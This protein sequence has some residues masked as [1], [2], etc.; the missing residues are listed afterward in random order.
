V[1]ED[2]KPM[3]VFLSVCYCVSGQH[4]G[5]EVSKLLHLSL[6]GLCLKLE[7]FWCTQ[8]QAA[9]PLCGFTPFFVEAYHLKNAKDL[10]F[11]SSEISSQFL[12][13]RLQRLSAEFPGW[14]FECG[15]FFACVEVHGVLNIC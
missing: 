4:C 12:R 2:V 14:Y 3:V 13:Q 1:D 5:V 8:I 6:S 7:K 10:L 15:R 11:E 9:L